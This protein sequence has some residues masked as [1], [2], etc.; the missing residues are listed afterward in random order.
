MLL[1]TLLLI[2]KS[3]ENNFTYLLLIIFFELW[4]ILGEK[5]GWEP[6]LP[7]LSPELRGKNLLIG[8]NFASAGVG[9]LNDTG[10]QFVSYS[11]PL[12]DT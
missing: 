8:A 5:M 1:Y 6:T 10:Y 7:Y 3:L 2:N 4:L 9:V 11:N 12:L